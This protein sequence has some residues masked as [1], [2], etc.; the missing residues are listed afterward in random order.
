MYEL[1]STL[2]HL[3]EQSFIHQ[4]L[5]SPM[6]GPGHFFIFEILYITGRSPWTGINQSESRYP[7]MVPHKHRINAHR[8]SF[9]E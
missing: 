8:Y 5:Y 7:Q 2:M 1:N 4:W 6:L 3:R 9:L